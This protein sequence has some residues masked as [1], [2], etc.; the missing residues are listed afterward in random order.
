MKPSAIVTVALIVVLIINL[1]TLKAFGE[2]Q[3]WLAL[4]KMTLLCGTIILMLIV[5]LGGGPKSVSC[6]V[7]AMV[8]P[9][10]QQ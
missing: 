3:F 9:Y 2:F 1:I 10:L 5:A 4:L 7:L 6:P 8:I